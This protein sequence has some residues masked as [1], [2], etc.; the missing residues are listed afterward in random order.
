[1]SKVLACH[2]G[3]VNTLLCFPVEADTSLSDPKFSKTG[4]ALVGLTY[5]ITSWTWSQKF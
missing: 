5:V 1:M 3:P 2:E 4:G